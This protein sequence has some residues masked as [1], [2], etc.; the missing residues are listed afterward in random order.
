MDFAFPPPPRP[1][2]AI[3]GE[4]PR[5]PVH[6]IYCAGHNYPDLAR[7]RTLPRQRERPYFFLKPADAVVPSDA[8][9]P[10]PP[11]TGDLHHEVSLVVA[12]G[13]GGAGIAPGRA[14][15]HVF[16][17][18]VGLDLARRDLQAE[19]RRL[20]RPWDA[21]RAFDRSAPCSAVHPVG[22]V[23]HPVGGAITLMVNGELRQAGDIADMIWSVAELIA[24]LSD[25]FELVAGDLV[26]TGTPAGVGAV[27]TGDHL[28]AS[29]AGVDELRVTIR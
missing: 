9:I 29:V 17:Y 18:A 3:A 4:Q 25:L 21:A 24:H 1:T 6:R 5:F 15:A 7:E 14:L 22:E 20:S 8:V 16:G 26:F 13:A 19:A 23:G 11:A 12:I 28:V 2:L 10:Y 27:R